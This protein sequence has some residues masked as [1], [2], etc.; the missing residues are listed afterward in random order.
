[1]SEKYR[2]ADDRAA[3]IASQL[4]V[5]GFPVGA[6]EEALFSMHLAPLLRRIEELEEQ[7]SQHEHSDYID[8]LYS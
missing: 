4:R 1:M 7:I 3:D 8:R 2:S 5:W 6:R